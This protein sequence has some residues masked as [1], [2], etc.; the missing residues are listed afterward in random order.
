MR[1]HG[2]EGIRHNCFQ[3]M[4]ENEGTEGE[5][6]HH[7]L[8]VP[9]V[10]SQVWASHHHLSLTPDELSEKEEIYKWK[11]LTTRLEEGVRGVQGAGNKTKAEVATS[12]ASS[13]FYH[14]STL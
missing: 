5:G 12:L 8:C 6:P 2:L 1:D 4:G 10:L 9:T 3:T 11:L 7:N 14:I 13:Y